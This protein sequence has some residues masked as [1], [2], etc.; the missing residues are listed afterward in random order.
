MLLRYDSLKVQW[1]NYSGQLSKAFSCYELSTKIKG[2][3]TND[4]HGANKQVRKI[5]TES[6]GAAYIPNIGDVRQNA[7]YVYLDASSANL[8]GCN[9]LG[10]YII[11][12]KGENCKASPLVWTSDKLKCVVKSPKAAESLSMQLVAE[13]AFLF[14][15]SF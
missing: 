1:P 13:Y 8:A 2:A 7:L 6:A 3:T 12:L 5:H 10:G 4:V 11:F 14:L 9:S 15:N